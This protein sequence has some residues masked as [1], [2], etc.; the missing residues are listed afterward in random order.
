MCVCCAILTEEVLDLEDTCVFVSI[1]VPVSVSVTVT[2]SVSVTASGDQ[3]HEAGGE[4]VGAGGASDGDERAP[5]QGCGSCV[6][7]FRFFR[8]VRVR[9]RGGGWRVPGGRRWLPHGMGGRPGLVS[10]CLSPPSRHLLLG[11]SVTGLWRF[12][13]ANSRVFRLYGASSYIYILYV[14]GGRRLAANSTV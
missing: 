9:V 1:Y 11:S 14:P 13:R 3:A 5:G 10:A 12:G 4:E 2:V 7:L 8:C 6:N